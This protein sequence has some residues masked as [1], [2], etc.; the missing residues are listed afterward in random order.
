MRPFAPVFAPPEA[1]APPQPRL[2]WL[3]YAGLA[4]LSALAAKGLVEGVY[5][6]LQY[7]QDFQWSPTVLLSE[8]RD[9]YDWY[10]AGNADERIILSQEP[11]YLHLLYVLLLPFAALPWP[12]AKA[13][14]AL[15]NAGMGVGCGVLL[16]R[17]AGLRGIVAAAAVAT[18]LAA[19]PV[20]HAIGNGQQ[21]LLA[22]L[23][24]TLAWRARD[25]ASG[26][27]AAAV[28]AS[29]YSFAPPVLLWLL[30]ERRA[31]AIAAAAVTGLAGLGAYAWLCGRT[32]LAV[33]AEPL[34]V[35]ARATHVGLADVMSLARALQF[36]TAAV[37]LAGLAVCGLGVAL[38][39][40]RRR[41]LD[42]FAIF[43]LLCQL[44]LF[45]LF[46]HLYDYVLLAPLF[47]RALTFPA[48]LRAL[49]LFYVGFFWFGVH[50]ID[51]MPAI[52]TPA[53][54]AAMALASAAMFV[55]VATA[56]PLQRRRASPM[57]AT[58]AAAL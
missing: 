25:R 18:F 29:K 45:T 52:K 48:G 49:T 57:A 46:H 16:A 19:S 32:P 55:A 38:L 54:I 21:S 28:G 40:R 43:A 24:L 3:G 47:C 7:S 42:D 14:W 9:A 37:Y 51:A 17:E 8:G 33:L 11:N 13:A 35:S 53:A 5:Y 31:S 34:Q 10:L 36:E 6:A 2:R 50:F 12:V 30:L 15:C 58:S 56:D 27:V 22:L 26:G 44:S 4:V 20:A 23:A 41:E 39:W 1:P